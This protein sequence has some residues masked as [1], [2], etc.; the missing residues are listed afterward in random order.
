MNTYK[1]L[2]KPSGIFGLRF[3]DMAVLMAVIIFTLFPINLLKVWIELPKW[4]TLLAYGL[5][6]LTY[7]LLRRANQ[8]KVP[9]Y[10]F[11]WLAYHFLTPRHVFIHQPLAILSHADEQKKKKQGSGRSHPYS[12]HRKR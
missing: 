5:I 10:L 1:V 9:G 8:K 11:S 12:H 7:M 6:L 2:E 3:E 4:I